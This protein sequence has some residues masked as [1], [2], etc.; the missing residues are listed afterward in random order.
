MLAQFELCLA[1]NAE[2]SLAH[3]QQVV[4]VI[5]ATLGHKTQ[6]KAVEQHIA[7]TVEDVVVFRQ[8]A[9]SVANA[10][11]GQYLQECKDC[12]YRR[13]LEDV[14]SRQEH[15]RLGGKV[16]YRKRLHQRLLMTRSYDVGTVL[17]QIIKPVHFKTLVVASRPELHQRA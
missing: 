16:E 10:V 15:R 9:L 12:T 1:G 7:R 5:V 13:L 8:I 3:L 6:R 11:D 14:G 17:G 4:A 2:H